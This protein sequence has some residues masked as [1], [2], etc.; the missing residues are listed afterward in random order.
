MLL[1]MLL[2]VVFGSASIPEET[3]LLPDLV[4][5]IPDFYCASTDHVR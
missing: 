1:A 4:Q 2:G 3:N 5:V